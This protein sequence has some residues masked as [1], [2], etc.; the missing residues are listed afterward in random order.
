MNYQVA[1]IDPPWSFQ[2]WSPAGDGRAPPYRTQ[3]GDWIASLP[4]TRLLADDAVVLL[5]VTDPMI[6]LALRCLDAWGLKY[7]TVGFYWTKEKPSGKEHIGTGYYTRANPEQCWIATRGRGLHR[8]SAAVRRWLHAPVGDHSV[9]PDEFYRRVEQLFGDVRRV[10]VFAR[11]PRAGWDVIGE[12]IDGNDI[13]DVLTGGKTPAA[14]DRQAQ[15]A[16][17][18]C[19]T[20]ES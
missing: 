4:I 12:E 19:D 15:L 9:K 1:V 6:P 10:D 11:R 14:M 5:W 20:I 18:G 16:L 7:K 8:E 2:T 3:H 13:S 17:D